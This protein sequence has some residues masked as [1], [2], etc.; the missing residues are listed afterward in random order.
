MQNPFYYD[1]KNCTVAAKR[2]PVSVTVKKRGD[3]GS[4]DG[5][6]FSLRELAYTHG[7]L[8]ALFLMLTPHNFV[9]F[10]SIW[11]STWF[12]PTFSLFLVVRNAEGRMSVRWWA[13]GGGLGRFFFFL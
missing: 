8:P 11:Q 2:F 10:I 1:W 6:P 5:D 3:R 7:R 12:V 4:F 13:P 9:A